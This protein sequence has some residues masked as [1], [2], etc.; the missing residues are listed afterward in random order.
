MISSRLFKPLL[1]QSLIKSRTL[2][3]INIET[4][5]PLHIMSSLYIRKKNLNFR[6]LSHYPKNQNVGSVIP[7]FIIQ[8]EVYYGE[9]A[10]GIM[11]SKFYFFSPNFTK[12]KPLFKLNLNAYYKIKIKILYIFFIKVLFEI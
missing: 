2:I 1:N 8:T 6:N 12:S 7:L 10:G 3:I 5:N 11:L 4:L 9:G